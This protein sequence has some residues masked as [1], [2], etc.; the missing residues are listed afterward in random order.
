M[1]RTE[2]KSIIEG[3]LFVS[4][5]EGISPEQIAKVLEIEGN[6]V[7]NI[8]EEMQKECEGAHRGLQIVQYAK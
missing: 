6:E 1:D 5:D 8:L 3:L 2:Q 4:G 7:I